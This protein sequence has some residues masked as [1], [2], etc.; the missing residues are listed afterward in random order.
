[1]KKNRSLTTWF[2]APDNGGA[3]GTPVLDEQF[4]KTVLEGVG[5]VRKTTDEMVAK[6]DNL[7]TTT[8]KAFEDLTKLRGEQTD[9]QSKVDAI[10]RIGVAL[11]RESRMANADPIARI[12]ACEEK[13]TLLNAL[14]RKAASAR[15]PDVR[16]SEAQRKALN[17]ADSPGSTHL[18]SDLAS[19]IYDTLSSYGIWS[20]FAVRNLGTKTTILPVKTVRPVAAWRTSEGGAISDDTNKAGTSGNADVRTMAVLI[21]VANE[22][23]QDAEIDVTSDVMMDFAE[24]IAYRLDWSAL[25]ADG[26][27]DATDGGYTGVFAG[28]TAATAAAGNVTAEG[29]QLED[30][31]RCLTT[32]DAGV[33]TRPCKW[34][35]HPQ[36]IARLLA[37]RDSNGR[38][39]FLTANEAPTF[40]GIGS[41]LGYPV[42]PSFAA[43]ST[44]AGG[45]KVAVFGDPAGMVIGVRRDFEFAASTEAG[46]GDYE[47]VFRG[48][49]RAAVKIRRA[50]AFAVLTLPAA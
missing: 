1:M 38:P 6:Y 32:V 7:D 40:G 13:R 44:N 8:K 42:V 36:I 30:F 25:Q 34:W 14:V 41:L 43:P 16:L 23:L 46:F 21:N 24:A 37:V 10:Q 27:S 4:R 19:D 31:L 49:M 2:L 47:T 22:L 12:A 15:N 33:L 29:L 35:I 50:E 3:G 11:Q 5:H 45:A 9:L 28:G 48:V 39:I 18:V 17:T 26:T 20:T